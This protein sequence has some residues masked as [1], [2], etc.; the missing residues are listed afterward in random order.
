MIR[1]EVS[2]DRT[3]G[4]VLLTLYRVESD[5]H[6][7]NRR[8][9]LSDFGIITPGTYRMYLLVYNDGI[10]IQNIHKNFINNLYRVI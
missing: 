1:S 7:Q 5:K 9:K 10:C 8:T 2:E 3:T 4:K 6:K